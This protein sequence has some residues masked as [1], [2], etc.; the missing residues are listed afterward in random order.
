M[1]Y[2]HISEDRLRF[3][4]EGHQGVRI[5]RLEGRVH[6]TNA[7]EFT[8]ELTMRSLYLSSS[9]AL[10]VDF[11]GLDSISSAG[12]RGLLVLKKSL[13]DTRTRFVFVGLSRDLE[14]I[15]RLTQFDFLFPIARD[16]DAASQMI[17]ASGKQCCHPSTVH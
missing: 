12:L 3:K 17:Q 13:E 2:A 6:H 1:L 16:I 7:A 14:E 9:E 5:L 8:N 11:S 15:F 10:I 4:T